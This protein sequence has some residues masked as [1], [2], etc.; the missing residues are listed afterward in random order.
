M[1]VGS[2]AVPYQRRR[3]KNSSQAE[4][5]WAAVGIGSRLYVLAMNRA[6][7]GCL[8]TAPPPCQADAAELQGWNPS[9]R[10]G[11]VLSSAR[12]AP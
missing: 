8:P 3:A 1:T 11:I 7:M 12:R 5:L 9:S 4:R 2:V 10:L 6:A